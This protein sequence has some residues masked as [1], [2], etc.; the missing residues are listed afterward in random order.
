MRKR[1]VERGGKN[2][3]FDHAKNAALVV[4]P[5]LIGSTVV[6]DGQ[7]QISV[8]VEIAKSSSRRGRSTLGER[9]SRDAGVRSTSEVAV[10]LG[11]PHIEVVMV[12][13]NTFGNSLR[14]R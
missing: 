8:I 5:Q 1:P 4:A 6:T 3:R 12:G 13:D 11:D 7:V 14:E 10:L 2:M 9:G